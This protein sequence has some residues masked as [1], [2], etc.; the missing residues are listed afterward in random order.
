MIVANAEQ[1][2]VVTSL[3]DPEPSPGLIDRCLVAA[4]DAGLSPLLI[5]TK[6]DLADPAHL[7]DLYDALDVPAVVCG[8][9]S[10]DNVDPEGLDELT[11]R[12]TVDVGAPAF[13]FV[14]VIRGK[15]DRNTSRGIDCSSLNDKGVA[16]LKIGST[17]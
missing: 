9:D 8:M 6:S 11:G 15:L 10:E 12:H 2:A 13:P 1:L 17:R 4:Y 16:R 7:L 5:L 3:A 14:R